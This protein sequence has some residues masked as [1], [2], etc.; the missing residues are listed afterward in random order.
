VNVV[1]D[2]QIIPDLKFFGKDKPTKNGFSESMKDRIKPVKQKYL[3]STAVKFI[4]T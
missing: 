1:L 3:Q 4:S 2:A